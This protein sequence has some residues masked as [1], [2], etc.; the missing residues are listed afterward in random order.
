M[1]RFL[2]VLRADE[3]DAL[4]HPQPG[5][6]QLD[7]LA[8]QVR[9]TGLPVRLRVGGDTAT[10]PAAA[11][12]T[13]YRLVQEALTNTLQ[14][15]AAGARASVTVDCPG[16]RVAVEVRDDGRAVPSPGG[17]GHGIA[18]MRDRAAAYGADVEAGPLPGG[19]WR[20]AATL[21]LTDAGEVR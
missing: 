11:Q 6:G 8:A 16:D 18:G 19:G 14:H 4:R 2:G 10:V 12:L 21:M 9:A 20:V 7:A 1:R 15:T 13:V 5:I 3:P 17:P